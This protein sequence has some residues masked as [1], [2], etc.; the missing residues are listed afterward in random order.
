MPQPR[1]NRRGWWALTKVRC[2]ATLASCLYDPDDLIYTNSLSR[3][4][5]LKLG[6]VCL[7][8]L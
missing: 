1:R 5:N 7:I 3:Y 4:H 8:R 2:M 6:H